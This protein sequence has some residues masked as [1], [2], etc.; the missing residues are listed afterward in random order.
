[1]G[2]ERY[3]AAMSCTAACDPGG[4]HQMSKEMVVNVPQVDGNRSESMV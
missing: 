4:S 1:M 3:A 2:M